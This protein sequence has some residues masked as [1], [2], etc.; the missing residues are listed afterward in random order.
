MN[1]GWTQG[2]YGLN[3]EN[4]GLKKWMPLFMGMCNTPIA[5]V[6]VFL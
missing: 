4:K 3:Y 2:L 5:I 1:E 6:I